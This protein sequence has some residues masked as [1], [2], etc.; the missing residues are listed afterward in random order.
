MILSN[1]LI[2]IL[3][4]RHCK[5]GILILYKSSINKML[6]LSN[7]HFI[8]N[9]A[10]YFVHV[11]SI[12]E[13]RSKRSQ[14]RI[15]NNL[16]CCFNPEWIST[17]EQIVW[18]KDW[19]THSLIKILIC[20]ISEWLSAFKRIVWEKN[21]M[22]YTLIMTVTWIFYFFNKSMLLNRSIEW[23]TKWITTKDGH[24]FHSWIYPCFNTNELI[25]LLNPFFVADWISVLNESAEWIIKWFTTCLISE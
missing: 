8:N 23:M 9:T 5:H 12:N 10:S 17:F 24:L 19:M 20:F 18:V 25:D 2:Y 1:K 7:L 13:N 14:N 21:W 3:V 15:S 22:M 6:I 16:C 11:C 4:W